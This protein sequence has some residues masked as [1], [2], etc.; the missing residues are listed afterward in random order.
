MNGETYKIYLI[1][2]NQTTHI[3]SMFGTDLTADYESRMVKVAQA[4]D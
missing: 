1:Y 2:E 3:Q 4:N